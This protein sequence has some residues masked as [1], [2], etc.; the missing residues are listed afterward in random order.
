[1]LREIDYEQKYINFEVPT[2]EYAYI[3]TLLI[4]SGRQK[5]PTFASSFQIWS[6]DLEN[7][8]P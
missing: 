6:F 3:A 8:G 5:G 4:D 1:M 7:P 2:R